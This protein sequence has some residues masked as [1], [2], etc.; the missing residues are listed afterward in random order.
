[1]TTPTEGDTM[2]TYELPNMPPNPHRGIY[3]E[4]N[5]G[6]FGAACTR[7]TYVFRPGFGWVERPV[8]DDT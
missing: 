5:A 4:E 8:E 7:T 2:P 3:T 6:F 1:M